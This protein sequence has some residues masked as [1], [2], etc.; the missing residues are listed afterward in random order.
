[1]DTRSLHAKLSSP[2]R[3]KPTPMEAKRK[4]DEKQYLAQINRERLDNVRMAKLKVRSRG[5]MGV[6]EKDGGG[7]D[8]WMVGL[9]LDSWIVG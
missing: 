3:R 9:L 7:G 4:L 6:G 2:D 8:G 5:F 1:M